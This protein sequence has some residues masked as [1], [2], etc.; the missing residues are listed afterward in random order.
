[1]NLKSSTLARSLELLALAA[2]V[3]IKEVQSG[4]LKSRMEQ[5]IIIAESLSKL[6]GA[7]MK[8]GQLLSL[9]LNDYFPPEAVAA[10]SKLQN[11]ALS[12]DFVEIEKILRRDLKEKYSLIKD[13]SLTP[14]GTAS[15]G[16]VHTAGFEGREIVLKVQYPGIAES[17]DSDLKILKN[18]AIAFCRLTG[19]DMDLEPLF[20]E[21]R[22]ILEQEVNYQLEAEFQKKYQFN[23][24]KMPKPHG[25]N[26]VVPEVI[27]SLSTR[28]VLAM[29]FEPG[30]TLRQWIHSEPPS[31][32][33]ES[34]AR[35]FLDLYFREFFDWGLVQTDSNFGNF[36][37]RTKPNPEL[38]LLDFGACRVYSREFIK[39]YVCLLQTASSG[40]FH[41]L[42]QE[43]I[44]FGLMDP[45]ESEDA[46]YAF[47]NLLQTAIRPFFP[48]NDN[49]L[50]DFSD[51][52]HLRNSQTAAR[53][54][55]Q[56]LKYSPPPSKIVFLHRKLAGVYAVLRQLHIKMDVR[57]YWNVMLNS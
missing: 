41:K 49:K 16:Q 39:Q 35:A 33:R 7:A 23:I 53:A 40:D 20:I 45:R 3:G 52:E 56:K 31:S 22:S 5:A 29:N 15:I 4:N 11:S 32:Q 36:L 55:S 27:E 1:M 18:M 2:R 54:L 38:V 43:G 19:R 37:V 46:F 30:V 9:E 57:P 12:I 17:I 42:K 24:S 34:M 14:I 6:K 48:K 8:A 13:L 28:N 25:W 44:A 51:E 26:C 10:F 47:D 21:F 50:F